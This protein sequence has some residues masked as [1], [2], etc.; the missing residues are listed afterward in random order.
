[1][2]DECWLR[3][4]GWFIIS[5]TKSLARRS[6]GLNSLTALSELLTF[7]AVVEPSW[8]KPVSLLSRPPELRHGVFYWISYVINSWSISFLPFSLETLYPPPPRLKWLYGD[9]RNTQWLDGFAVIQHFRAVFWARGFLL[10]L[11]RTAWNRSVSWF[12]SSSVLIPGGL[13]GS[14]LRRASPH[15]EVFILS[16]QLD[17]SYHLTCHLLKYK[18]ADFLASWFLCKNGIFSSLAFDT[19]PYAFSRIS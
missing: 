3:T 13:P 7:T 5:T 14:S 19:T 8:W 10:H 16:S 18:E 12:I 4:G 17:I 11:D 1:M 2:G 15:R 9:R 6:W